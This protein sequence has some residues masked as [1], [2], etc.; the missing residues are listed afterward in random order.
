MFTRRK[1]LMGVLVNHSV[2]TALTVAVAA[3]ILTL[4]V[5]LVYQV[6]TTG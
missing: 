3:L 6:F 1:T 2:T 5:Y 4:N